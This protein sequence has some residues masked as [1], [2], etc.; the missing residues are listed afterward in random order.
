MR[1]ILR[2]LI[3][4]AVGLLALFGVSRAMTALFGSWGNPSTDLQRL[5]AGGLVGFVLFVILAV[6]AT[7][8]PRRESLRL[9][10]GR[11]T[12]T[13]VLVI[14]AASAA[15]CLGGTAAWQL[16]HVSYPANWSRAQAALS[17]ARGPALLAVLLLIGVASAAG[18]DLFF[19]GAIQTAFSRRYGP[20]LAIAVTS[21]GF[22][23]YQRDPLRGFEAALLGILAGLVTEW[24]GSVW[25]GVAAHVTNN[26]LATALAPIET[27]QEP[28]TALA[29]VALTLLVLAGSLTWL[30]RSLS[31]PSAELR[32]G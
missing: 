17:A 9:S 13:H 20:A 25:A 26:M 12:G 32:A 15:F 31:P 22:A 6:A 21:L 7:E 28:A 4:W 19:R 29:A 11:L 23:I 2:V 14:V 18:Q 27:A 10:A 30:R 24:S 16:L 5:L 8:P 1:A 3:V